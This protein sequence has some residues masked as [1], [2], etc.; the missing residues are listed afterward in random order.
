MPVTRPRIVVPSGP[1]SKLGYE[2]IA[3]Q[4][5]CE[6]YAAIR[7]LFNGM[8][9]TFY[10]KTGLP[11]RVVRHAVVDE[12]GG[13]IYR[14]SGRL[15]PTPPQS[16]IQT[17]L[18][19]AEKPAKHLASVYGA[20]TTKLKPKKTTFAKTSAKFIAQEVVKLIQDA[21]KAAGS[22]AQITSDVGTIEGLDKT[23]WGPWRVRL[24]I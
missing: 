24:R 13:K 8:E 6:L 3:N 12:T 11:G 21:N 15:E 16:G 20:A 2:G 14:T 17:A 7:H 9:I 19:R 10:G 22:V 4:S 18:G 23:G 5:R 1:P